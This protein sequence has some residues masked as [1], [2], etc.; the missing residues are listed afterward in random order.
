MAYLITHADYGI[1]LGSNSTAA[2]WSLDERNDLPGAA[3]TFV[4][5]GEAIAHISNWT[6]G[7]EPSAYRYL[8]VSDGGGGFVFE[9]DLIAQG[10]DG[11]T[12]VDLSC[13]FKPK[14]F[15]ERT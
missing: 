7:N 4:T 5:L 3:Q 11:W 6:F 9:D 8:E 1:Y 14:T 13:A 15:A 2:Y 10:F 12:P